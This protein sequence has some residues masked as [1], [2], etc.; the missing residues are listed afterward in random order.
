[1]KIWSN[2]LVVMSHILP[3]IIFP[4]TLKCKKYCTTFLD[5]CKCARN[6]K[7]DSSEMI[8]QFKLKR[9]KPFSFW[10]Q[11]LI[12]EAW[13]WQLFLWGETGDILNKVV[14]IEMLHCYTTRVHETRRHWR[15]SDTRITHGKKKSWEQVGWQIDDEYSLLLPYPSRLLLTR[16][17]VLTELLVTER[18]E[19]QARPDI[20]WCGLWRAQGRRAAQDQHLVAAALSSVSPLA[21]CTSPTLPPA[22]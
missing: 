6:I 1:M 11:W 5:L 8:R 13:I 18:G 22:R 10:I 14:R 15:Q 17:N 9:K 7:S 12:I 16:G 21:Q 20:S 3:F 19:T 4:Q 2:L